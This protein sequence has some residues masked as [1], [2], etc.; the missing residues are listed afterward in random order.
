MTRS[1]NQSEFSPTTERARREIL[2]CL[3]KKDES[4]QTK[5]LGSMIEQSVAQK[6]SLTE[7]LFD[8]VKFL[9]RAQQPSAAAVSRINPSPSDPIDEKA[10]EYYHPS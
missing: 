7:W 9:F 8:K 2:R 3:E 10:F 4:D 6:P 1:V 5:L